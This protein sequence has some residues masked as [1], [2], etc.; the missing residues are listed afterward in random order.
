MKKTKTGLNASVE[1]FTSSLKSLGLCTILGHEKRLCCLEVDVAKLIQ[2]EVIDCSRSTC[3]IILLEASVNLSDSSIE[4]AKNP[5]VNLRSMFRKKR[6]TIAHGGLEIGAELGESETDSIP[7]LVAEVT[8]ANDT[9]DIEVDITTLSS[10]CT[11][12]ETKCI[13]TTF[14]NTVGVLLALASLSLLNLVSTEVTVE[15]L[16]VECLKGDTLDDIDGVNDV[17][18]TLADLTAVCITDHTVKEDITERQF[19]S[20]HERHHNHT[21]DP[22]EEDIVTSLEQCSREVFGKIWSLFWPAKDREWEQGR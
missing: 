7:D 8:I 22:E 4:T 15:K 14:C 12:S 1:S 2:P 3:K 6:S 17:A 16:L 20:E 18:E 19:V 13:S 10:V 5:A 21:S 9:I 11:K